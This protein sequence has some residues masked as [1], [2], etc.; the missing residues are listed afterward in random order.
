MATK[1]STHDINN[2]RDRKIFFDANVLIYVF[3]PSASPYLEGV[4]SS[5]YGQLLRQKNDLCVDYLVISEVIN[6]TF[7]IE[8]DKYKQADPINRKNIPFKKYRDLEEGKS[9]L[10]DI[11]LMVETNILKHFKIIGKEFTK[12]DIQSFLTINPLDF[13]DK[14]ILMTCQ[15]NSCVLLTNDADFKTADIDIL[16]SNNNLL[17][18]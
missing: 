4:Y 6:R 17:N 15:K 8:Y 7:R 9:A 11:Y 3:W 14:G 10:E 5:A 13:M 1:Y 16:T 2:L 12:K 18:N